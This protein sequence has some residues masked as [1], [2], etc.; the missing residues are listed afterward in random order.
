MS[1][2]VNYVNQFGPFWASVWRAAAQC[3]LQRLVVPADPGLSGVS[4][5][6]CIA[7]N[8]PKILADLKTYKENIREQSLK[9]FHHKAEA[10]AGESPE[11]KLPRASARCWP[12]AAGRC[13]CSSGT[14]WLDGGRQGGRGQQDRLHRRAQRHR[15]GVPGGLLDGDLIVRAQ[16]VQWQDAPLLAAA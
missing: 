11:R 1:R 12:A 4:T 5:S 8:T 14:K 6:L 10:V 15:A 2:L 13:A 16:M 9:A 3:G 7:R